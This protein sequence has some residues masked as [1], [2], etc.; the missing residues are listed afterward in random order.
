[1]R[2]DN[3]HCSRLASL[4]SLRSLRKS[5]FSKAAS[6]SSFA[7]RLF[8]VISLN[9]SGVAGSAG[10]STDSSP[11]APAPAYGGEGIKA[12]SN[13]PYAPY[14]ELKCS[15]SEKIVLGGDITQLPTYASSRAVCKL[16]GALSCTLA[17][18]SCRGVHLSSLNAAPY[19]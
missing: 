9:S 18:K 6:R 15:V 16:F 17:A 10:S 19:H 2:H 8:A 4:F 5:E 13:I 14:L 1:M 12:H 7:R 11:N 3:T